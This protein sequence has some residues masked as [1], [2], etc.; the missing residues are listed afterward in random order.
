[1]VGRKGNDTNDTV[2]FI[3]FGDVEE[4]YPLPTPENVNKMITDFVVDFDFQL[5]PREPTKPKVQ[6]KLTVAEQ[7][8]K[9]KKWAFNNKKNE[10]KKRILAKSKNKIKSIKHLS[11]SNKNKNNTKKYRNSLF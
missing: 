6:P 11:L 1:M 10:F 9:A 7:R 8:E 4:I 5:L 3:D 2:Y